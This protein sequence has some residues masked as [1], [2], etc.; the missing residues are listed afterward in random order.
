MTISFFPSLQLI[1]S[2]KV[3]QG[4]LYTFDLEIMKSEFL[5]FWDQMQYIQ[6][7]KEKVSV[8]TLPKFEDTFSRLS[9][10]PTKSEKVKHL[11]LPAEIQEQ[12]VGL[13]MA[14]QLE[15]KHWLESHSFISRCSE[16]NLKN[17]LVWFSFGILDRFKTA[18]NYI[19]GGKLN[20][21]GRFHLACK[22][23]FKDAMRMLWGSMSS[24]DKLFYNSYLSVSESKELVEHVLNKQTPLRWEYFLRN[25]GKCFFCANYLGMRYYFTELQ[26]PEMRYLCISYALAYDRVHYFDLYWC[27]SLIND[28]E[29]NAILTRLPKIY[30]HR[31]FECFLNWPFQFMFLDVTNNFRQHINKEIFFKLIRIILVDKIGWRFQDYPYIELFECFWHSTSEQCKNLVKKDANMYALVKYILGNSYS[32]DMIEYTNLKNFPR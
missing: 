22:Y 31:V 17:G 28:N 4:I 3:A 15:V 24:E 29:L 10:A 16:L 11:I 8:I 14:L 5:T 26:L 21:D 18:Q 13:I 32:F 2:A 25:K 30:I 12:M 7:I 20:I 9:I 27:L 19:Q 6:Q 1:A 23:Y